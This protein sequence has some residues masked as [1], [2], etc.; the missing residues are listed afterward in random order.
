MGLS[1]VCVSLILDV[2]I[3]LE[4][5]NDYIV[6]LGQR[7]HVKEPARKSFFVLLGRRIVQEHPGG[8]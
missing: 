8:G 1:R 6:K 2:R 5:F 7:G 3:K 4:G